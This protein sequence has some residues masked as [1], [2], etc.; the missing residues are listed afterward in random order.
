MRG[1]QRVLGGFGVRNEDVQLDL[2]GRT[3]ARRGRKVDAGVAGRGRDAGQGP[4]LVLDLDNQV[5]GNRCALSSSACAGDSLRSPFAAQ[6]RIS[7]GVTLLGC[8][9]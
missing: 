7:P 2:L 9:R 4:G 5:E 6:D 8:A 1:G 3:D